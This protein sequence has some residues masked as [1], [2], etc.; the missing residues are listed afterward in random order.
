MRICVFCGAKAGRGDAYTRVAAELG[1]ELARRGIGVVYG[2]GN[3]GMMGALA[4]AVADAGGEVIGVIPQALVNKELAHPRLTTTHIVNTMHE[5]KKLMADLSDGFIALPGGYGTLD[6]WYEILTW[7]QLGIHRK[8]C[9]MLNI[10]GYFD[11]LLEFLA[12]AVQENFL[13]VPTKSLFVVS[14]QIDDLLAQMT[15]YKPP[16]MREWIAN[17]QR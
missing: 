16:F 8:P 12:H 10:E 3:V 2:A 11:K 7:G 15:D 17:E 6:E 4:D 13:D 14:S 5:R 9:G 1:R